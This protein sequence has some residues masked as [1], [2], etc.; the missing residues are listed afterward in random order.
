[1]D[2]SSIES[3]VRQSKIVTRITFDRKKKLPFFLAPTSKITSTM[4]VHKKVRISQLSQSRR[5]PLDSLFSTHT[6]RHEP[7]NITSR[8]AKSISQIQLLLLPTVSEIELRTKVN[9]WEFLLRID[10]NLGFEVRE[11]DDWSEA[12]KL[13]LEVNLRV[14]FSFC[15]CRR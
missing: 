7:S 8:S 12:G 1:M 2:I 10:L 14:F 4:P 5:R 6:R 11:T 3:S 9:C 15:W 13:L